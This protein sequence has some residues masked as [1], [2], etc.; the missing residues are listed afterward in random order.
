[1]PQA[2][3]GNVI[4]AQPQFLKRFGPGQGLQHRVG[5]SSAVVWYINLSDSRQRREMPQAIICKRPGIKLNRFEMLKGRNVGER[6]V[7]YVIDVLPIAM[8][9]EALQL[10]K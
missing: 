5:K 8:Q 10:F 9:T 3:V 6:C 2:G 4:A 1:M 7:G